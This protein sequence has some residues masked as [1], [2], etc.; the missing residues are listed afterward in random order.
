M[1]LNYKSQTLCN[2]WRI[3]NRANHEPVG[4]GTPLDKMIYDIT[5][6]FLLIHVRKE[7]VNCLK[8]L[9]VLQFYGFGFLRIAWE[10]GVLLVLLMKF[11]IYLW[12]FSLKNKTQVCRSV[13][14][15]CRGLGHQEPTSGNNS[16]HCRSCMRMKNLITIQD[17]GIENWFIGAFLFKIKPALQAK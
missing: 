10:N 7:N 1:I 14:V 5:W 16:M 11:N 4:G 12:G 13:S 2:E 17:G 15:C 3:T 8:M 6:L 9:V